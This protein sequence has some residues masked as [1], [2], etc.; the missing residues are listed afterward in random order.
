MN[1]SMKPGC[2]YSTW[3]E[4]S[5]WKSF[6]HEEGGPYSS[7]PSKT[8]QKLALWYPGVHTDWPYLALLGITQNQIQEHYQCSDAE[9][10]VAYSY[11]FQFLLDVE[12]RFV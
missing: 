7:G 4:H 5:S 10:V 6:Y 2:E 8:S 9:A 1:Y 11:V 12:S 3:S